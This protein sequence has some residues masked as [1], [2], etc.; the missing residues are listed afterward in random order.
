MRAARY[1]TALALL[2]AEKFPALSPDLVELVTKFDLAGPG[3]FGVRHSTLKA[4]DN[5]STREAT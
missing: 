5:N 4:L 1:A 3:S 2:N